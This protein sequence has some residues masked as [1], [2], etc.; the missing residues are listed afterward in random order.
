[1]K[2]LKLRGNQNRN[3]NVTITGPG[4][5]LGGS[6]LKRS[7]S[8]RSVHSARSRRSLKAK[9]ISSM[10]KNYESC[11]PMGT[12]GS[13]K[14]SRIG[15]KSPGKGSFMKKRSNSVSS[16]KKRLYTKNYAFSPN[17]NIRRKRLVNIGNI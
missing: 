15:S 8:M 17:D 16:S 14:G 7:N 11:G 4:G 1:M 10:D 5:A 12:S 2:I 13:I 3:E 9:R 6:V